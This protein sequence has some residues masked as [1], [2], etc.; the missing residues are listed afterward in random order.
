MPFLKPGI[1][2][3]AEG[4]NDQK[5]GR[6]RRQRFRHGLGDPPK[7]NAPTGAGHVFNRDQQHTGQTET[8]HV[9]GCKQK[10]R[11]ATLGG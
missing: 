11:G 1:K 2:A 9:V 3:M 10:V 8:Q 6:P 5:Q 4:E 7:S